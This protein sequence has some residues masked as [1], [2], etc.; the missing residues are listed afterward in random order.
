MEAL[1]ELLIVSD[2]ESIDLTSMGCK[3]RRH[4][5]TGCTGPDPTNFWES[6]MGPAQNCVA[7]Y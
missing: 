4:H 2:L 1:S 6:D 3:H 5:R 7:K